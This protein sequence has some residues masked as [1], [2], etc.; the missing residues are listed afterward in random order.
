MKKIA[1]LNENNIYHKI[2]EILSSHLVP[3]IECN[4]NDIPNMKENFAKNT[5]YL[6]NIESIESFNN[7]VIEGNNK[8]NTF[9][10]AILLINSS[11]F[12][13]FSLYSKTF[14]ISSD[15]FTKNILLDPQIITFG[16]DNKA[17]ITYSSIME[18]QNLNH[19]MVYIQN[20]FNTLYNTKM[21]KFE[22]SLTTSL[23]ENENLIYLL[24]IISLCLYLDIR[25]TKNEFIDFE[26]ENIYVK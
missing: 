13:V 11:Y 1:I 7:Y 4:L 25:F 18:K 26:K 17:N 21:I 20:S 10:D 22:F 9:F 24:G 6:F 15:N 5:L 8:I 12:E 2:T 23:L 19:L 14:I 16:F 3:F